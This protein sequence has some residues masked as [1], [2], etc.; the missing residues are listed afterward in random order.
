MDDPRGWRSLART[1]REDVHRRS[2]ASIE[3]S[4]E[5]AHVHKPSGWA[6][7]EGLGEVMRLNISSGRFSRLISE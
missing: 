5:P 7:E 4:T 1:L 3:A 2:Q 6:T